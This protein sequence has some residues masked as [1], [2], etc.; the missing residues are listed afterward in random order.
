MSK[1]SY[2]SHP[3]SVC[4]S[5]FKHMKLSLTFSYL[6]LFGSFKSIIHAFIPSLFITSTNDTTNH[7]KEILISSGCR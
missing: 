2:F 3:N 1:Y 6:M 5:Y 7:I 4:L